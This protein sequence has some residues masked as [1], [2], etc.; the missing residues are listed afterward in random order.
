MA[1]ADRN[2]SGSR[3]VAI[4]VVSVLVFA[5]GY[6]FVTGLTYNYVKKMQEK[7]KAF[8]VQEPPPPPPD[9]P[10]PPPPPDQPLPPPP[11]VSPPPIVQNPN[12][13]PVQLQTQPTPPPVF[14]PTPKAAPP[15]PPPPVINKQAAPKGNPGSWFN[16]ETD[17]PPSARAQNVQGR[18][19]IRVTIDTSGRVSGCTVLTSSGNTDLDNTTCRVA[20]RRGRYSPA[21]DQAGNPMTSSATIPVRWQ[22]QE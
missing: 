10:P 5:M 20:T 6:A 13:P 4:V 17:Y 21:L 9:E 19:V 22:L 18:T 7:L 1:Y 3:V 2:Q 14:I 8:D 15:P 12:P 16:A 11:V